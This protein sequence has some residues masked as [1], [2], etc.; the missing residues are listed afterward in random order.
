MLFDDLLNAQDFVQAA[1]NLA[2]EYRS[3]HKLPSLDQLGLVVESVEDTASKLEALGIG[4]FLILEGPAKLW[5]ER[6]QKRNFR[7]K[8][9]LAYHR[10]VELELLEPGEGSDFY[11]QSL[12]P[13]GGITIQHLGFA[14]KDIEAWAN[15]LV[16]SD[17]SVWIRGKLKTGPLTVDFLYLDTI[18]E[19]GFVIEFLCWRLLGI[20]F[21]LPAVV[22]HGIGRLEKW[23]G[24]RSIAA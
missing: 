19:T 7:G 21:R 12:D 6:G 5:S 10:S 3:K 13:G 15:R 2:R 17:V 8:M 9:G 22:E 1:D 4:P 20:P 14:V 18:P 23:T 16:A 24:K 11:R